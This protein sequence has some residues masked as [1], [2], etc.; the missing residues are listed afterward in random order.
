MSDSFATPWT[1]AHHGISQVR[2]LEWVAISFSRGSSW[3][4]NW[5]CISCTGR[6]ILYHWATE[7]ALSPLCVHALSLL[8]CLTLCDPINFSLSGSSVHGILQQELEW[9]AMTSSGGSSQPRGQ[10]CVSCSSLIAGRFYTT[11][12]KS[13]LGLNYFSPV[14]RPCFLWQLGMAFPTILPEPW[15]NPQIEI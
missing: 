11:E 5:T 13:P 7:E 14:F 12:P 1:V 3:P 4:R 15:L 9:V 6:Q 2:I 8:S 10:T